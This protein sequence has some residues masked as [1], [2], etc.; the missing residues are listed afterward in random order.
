MRNRSVETGACFLVGLLMTA[1]TAGAGVMYNVSV[2]AV[3]E[4]FASVAPATA[5][6]AAVVSQYVVDG[7]RVRVGGPDAKT[8]YLFKDGI[9]FVIE[10]AAKSVR[11]FKR[12]T[13]SQ[14]W[15]HYADAVKQL[16]DAAANAPLEDRTAA[17]RKAADMKA[18]SDRLL[19]PVARVY[20][21]TPRFDSVEGRT[22]RIWEESENDAKRLEICVAP[23]AT[24]PGGAE[25][26]DGMK[27]LSQFRRGSYFAL[28]V[29]FGLSAWWSDV[30]SLDGVPRSP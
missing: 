6:S 30:A 4:D 26:L 2:R 12:A 9:V 1:G 24:V 17:E 8:V 5:S 7:G 14:V 29:D 25:I 19:Q 20:R 16:Q 22:C 23:V 15:A 13:L 18:A 10:P 3:D 21:M 11:V 27:T 28:G